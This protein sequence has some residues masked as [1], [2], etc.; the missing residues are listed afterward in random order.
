[1]DLR[2]ITSLRRSKKNETHGFLLLGVPHHQSFRLV[3]P[4]AIRICQSLAQANRAL[5]RAA[6]SFRIISLLLQHIKH[7]SAWFSLKQN[8]TVP[9]DHFAA[10]ASGDGWPVAPEKSNGIFFGSTT[11]AAPCCTYN[12]RSYQR[13]HLNQ[14]N[15]RFS[16]QKSDP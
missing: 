11:T 3:R 9:H 4:E 15:P 10:M 7:H 6:R 12:C 13:P 8:P 14:G 2:G 16:V 1:M 5:G